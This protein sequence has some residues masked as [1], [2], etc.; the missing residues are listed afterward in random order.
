MAHEGQGEAAQAPG[1]D[2]EGDECSTLAKENASLR[3][4][5]LRS[6]A[7]SENDRRRS[8]RG[9]ADARQYAIAT[10][11]GELLTVIDNLERALASAA[12]KPQQAPGDAAL[13]DG[14]RTTQRLLPRRSSGSACAGWM[15]LGAPF[16]PTMH[17]AVTEID[18][19]SLRPEAWCASWRRV[20]RFTSACFAPLV[21]SS[22]GRDRSR[23]PLSN[24]RL[25]SHPSDPPRN[26]FLLE[27][28]VGAAELRVQA[29]NG[30]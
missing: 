23:N 22:P 24:P 27:E 18:E 9:I 6:L 8:E 16:D 28:M 30:W 12:D 2:S 3:D 17:E 13:L 26:M 10:F 25:F 14:V 5:L 19:A 1:P 29:R 20:I 21:S 11:A 7:D 15:P 4:R